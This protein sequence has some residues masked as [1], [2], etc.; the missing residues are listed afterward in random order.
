[1]KKFTV[2]LMIVLVS[3]CATHVDKF[4]YLKEWNDKW[5]QCD[6]AVKGNI[7][8]FPVTDWFNQLTLLEKR[9]V[10]TYVYQLKQYQC[11]EDEAIKLRSVLDEYDIKA[12]DD[13][14]GG[15]IFFEPPSNEKIAHLDSKE[16]SLLADRIDGPF[17]GY[18]TAE[19]L[20]L[21]ER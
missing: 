3:G 20:G 5:Q 21:I 14:L 9:D 16:I 4:S 1:M 10:F 12:L 6:K 19:R 8:N 17:K 13:I 15:F 7:I 18:E 11:A 2:V